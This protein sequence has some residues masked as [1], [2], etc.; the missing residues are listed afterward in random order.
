MPK[1]RASRKTH[2]ARRVSLVRNIAIGFVALVLIVFAAA[3]LY[4]G[5]G[6][7]TPDELV[8]NTHYRALSSPAPDD[9][10]EPIRVTEF[11]TYACVVC[12]NF[13]PLVERW[14]R[15]QPD[16]VVLERV[17]VSFNSPSWRLLSRAYYALESA[18]ALERNHDR[19]FRAIHDNNRQFRTAEGLADFVDG[20]GVDRDTFLELMNSPAVRRAVREADAKAAEYQ[21]SGVPGLAVND[22]YVINMGSTTRPGSL[23]IADHLIQKIRDE[24]TDDTAAIGT[25]ETALAGADGQP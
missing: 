3:G 20:Q 15:R 14:Y 6:V 22:R 23:I 7:G 25:I 4:Y 19:L 11:F 21:I 2:A 12:R 1:T 13:E 8:E 9:P 16:D 17:P 24:R 5:T 10:A 18:D